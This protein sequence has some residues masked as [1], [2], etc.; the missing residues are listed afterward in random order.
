[1]LVAMMAAYGMEEKAK[2]SAQRGT[3]G[4]CWDQTISWPA[5]PL[6]L[7]LPSANRLKDWGVGKK[8]H[9]WAAKEESIQHISEDD[10]EKQTLG[11]FNGAQ[12]RT[13]TVR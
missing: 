12:L 1:M 13:V 11:V 5:G 8:T 7:Y 9:F 6:S 2:E 10:L 4:S 3:D